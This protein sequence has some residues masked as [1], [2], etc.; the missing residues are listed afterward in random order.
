[1]SAASDRPP[2][3]TLLRLGLWL[4]VLIA[5]VFVVALVL[6]AVMLPLTDAFPM[7]DRVVS[8]AEFIAATWPTLCMLPVTTA[9]VVAIAVGVWK[10]RAWAR[11]VMMAYTVASIAWIAFVGIWSHQPIVMS[12]VIDCAL[13][14]FTAWYLYAKPSVVAYY[15]ALRARAGPNGP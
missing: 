15:D 14:A 13:A 11:P 6:L 9:F 3:P 8:R 10:E 4:S 2:M 12:L 1:M 7:G 5:A